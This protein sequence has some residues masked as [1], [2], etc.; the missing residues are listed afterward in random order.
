M[1]SHGAIS[2]KTLFLEKTVCNESK[3]LREIVHNQNVSEGC[4]D[5]FS[6]VA[7]EVSYDIDSGDL[8]LPMCLLPSSA[9]QFKPKGK[10]GQIH[11]MVCKM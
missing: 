4:D 11:K 6:R 9:Q 3:Y 1:W 8:L 7:E 10:L 2:D 5:V